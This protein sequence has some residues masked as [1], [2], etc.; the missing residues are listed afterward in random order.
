LAYKFKNQVDLMHMIE[1]ISRFPQVAI[2]GQI[3]IENC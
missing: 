3:K 2:K 1:K